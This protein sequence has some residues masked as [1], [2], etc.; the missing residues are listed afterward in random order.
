MSNRPGAHLEGLGP[1][2]EKR[3]CGGRKVKKKVLVETPERRKFL[4]ENDVG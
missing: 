4:G 3:P 1:C 2:P